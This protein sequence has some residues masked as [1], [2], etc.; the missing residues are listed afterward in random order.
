M[1]G[2]SVLIKEFPSADYSPV[3]SKTG[4]TQE[5]P[6]VAGKSPETAIRVPEFV[7]A[8]FYAFSSGSLVVY[9]IQKFN[10][11]LA[12]DPK[13][14]FIILWIILWKFLIATTESGFDVYPNLTVNY[15]WAHYTRDDG[16]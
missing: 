14:N 11:P 8:K 9:P 4:R 2:Q 6:K 13:Q 15:F 7:E 16:I 5:T 3:I 10:E 12:I 1:F